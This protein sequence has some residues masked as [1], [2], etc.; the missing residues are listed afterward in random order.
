MKRIFY[1]ALAVILT[2]VSCEHDGNGGGGDVPASGV[3]TINNT[4]SFDEATQSYN[5]Y[6]FS[7]VEAS[8]V[9]VLE[10]G[11]Y[12]TVGCANGTVNLQTDSYINSFYLFGAYD[13]A[14]A[15]ENAFNGLTSASVAAWSEWANPVTV[16]QVWIFRTSEKNYVKLW[17]K[18][19]T[20]E[21]TDQ[22]ECTFAWVY[23]PDG[24]LTFPSE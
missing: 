19:I 22:V 21:E 10:S 16:N 2:F 23:Q 4:L 7:F 8:L 17:I 13:D 5:L 18:A 15:A 1:I 11:D 3:A 24:T 20:I 6:G 12:I 14:V 9:S